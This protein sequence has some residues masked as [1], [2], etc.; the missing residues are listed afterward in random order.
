MI[1]L[2]IVSLYLSKLLKWSPVML[3]IIIMDQMEK[4]TLTAYCNRIVWCPVNAFEYLRTLWFLSM[5]GGS[6]GHRR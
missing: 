3:A 1:I 2:A 4:K 5:P 6:S